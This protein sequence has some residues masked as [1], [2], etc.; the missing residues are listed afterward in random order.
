MFED[1]EVKVLL[2]NAG[3]GKTS[4]LIKYI[5]EELKTRRPE[6]IAFVTFTKKGADEGS[7]IWK[8]FWSK[9]E[10]VANSSQTFVSTFLCKGNKSNL[11]WSSCF[12]LFLNVLD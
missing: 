7:E 6:E 3:A 12:Q 4:T 2:A 1:K 11:F 10:L 8:L 5:E 9:T